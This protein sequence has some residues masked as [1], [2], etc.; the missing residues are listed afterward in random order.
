MINFA[1]SSFTWES[2]PWGVDPHY[3][4]KGGF[5][6]EPGQVYH[7]RFELEARCQVR[8]L[9]NGV[10]TETFL[11]AP[12][13]SEYTIASENLFQIPSGE[14]RMAFS[15]QAQL[16]MSSRPSWEDQ[17][18]ANRQLLTDCFVSHSID[19]RRFAKVSI[20]DQ[21][22]AVSTA[23]LANDLL[24]GRCVYVDADG[25][26][27][28]EVEFPINVMNL[29]VADGEFQVCTGP[30]LVPDLSTWDGS[31]I[32]R[33][34]VAHV[35]FS[36]FDRVEFILRRDVEAAPSE[37]EWLDAPRGR[38]R[39]ELHDPDNPPDGYHNLGRPRPTVY[40]EVWDFPSTNAVLRAD[41]E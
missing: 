26:F 39:L 2:R 22:P 28:V 34:Y 31:D 35:A 7:V 11:G 13:R 19:I 15:H 20:L 5:V 29:N 40:N 16:K 6:G 4:W 25:D 23:T 9:K 12:C 32:R 3:K 36:R 10:S 38:D 8:H 41:G 30:V 21:A 33:G 37:R 24:S 1:R 18:E 17:G 27:E 14:W